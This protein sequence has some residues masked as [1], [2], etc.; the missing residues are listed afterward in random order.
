MIVVVISVR[1][2]IIRILIVC[3]ILS[4]LRP[5]I[6][7]YKIGFIIMPRASIAS[8]EEGLLIVSSTRYNT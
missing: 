3:S 5:M 8:W 4:F 6:K 1:L 7:S 2:T